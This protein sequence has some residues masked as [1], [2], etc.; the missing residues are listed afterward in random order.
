MS[1]GT[2]DAREPER[3]ET[4]VVGAGQAGLSVGY[5][6]ERQGLPF[7]ILDAGERVGDSWRAR[8]DSLR[9]F[10]PAR[11]NGLDGLPFP[12][13]R[14]SFPSKDEMADYLEAYAARFELPVRTGVRVDRLAR[15]GSGF[16]LTAGDLRLEAD[17][18]VV[19][20]SNWQQ[21]SAADLRRR[22]RPVRRPA[23]LRRLPQPLPAARGRGPRR[24][25]GQLG[26]RDRARAG[27]PPVDVALRAGTPATSRF[28]SRASRHGTCSPI[29]CC[30][31]P[32]TGS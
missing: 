19:A 27:P 26:S 13:S 23:A 25:S 17:N 21:P 24:R 12:A 22:A 11:H 2:E 9:L 4:V 6:L 5:H 1:N 3:V 15:N 7:A 31:A 28:A 20:M 14:H 29:S 32:S 16:V 18:V 30:A 8:W 10:T